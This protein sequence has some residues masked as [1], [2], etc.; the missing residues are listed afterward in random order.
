MS[1]NIAYDSLREGCLKCD[2]YYMCELKLL[3]RLLNLAEI[4]K[5]EKEIDYFNSCIAELMGG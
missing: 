5:N 4:N 3:K 1:C 2:S